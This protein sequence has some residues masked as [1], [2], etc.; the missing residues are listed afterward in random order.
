MFHSPSSI[1]LKIDTL[2]PL[3]FVYKINDC[4]QTKKRLKRAHGF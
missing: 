4:Q 1:G 2:L 3:L